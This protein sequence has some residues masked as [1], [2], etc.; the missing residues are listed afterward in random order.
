MG[1]ASGSSVMNEIIEV[2]HKEIPDDE[3]NNFGLRKRLYKGIIKALQSH[4]WDTEDESL[5]VD[6]AFDQALEEIHPDWFEK[7]ENF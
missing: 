3:Q 7:E 5:G 6:P 2:V 4:D 1:W